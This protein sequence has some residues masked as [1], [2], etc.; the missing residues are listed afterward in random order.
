MI[1]N[2]LIRTVIT[3]CVLTFIQC[4]SSLDTIKERTIECLNQ[5]KTIE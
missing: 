4:Q 5:S 1:R 3:F 2:I